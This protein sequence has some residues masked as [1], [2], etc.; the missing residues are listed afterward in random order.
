MTSTL[1]SRWQEILR[2]EAAAKV[3]NVLA[4]A[5]QQPEGRRLPRW[6]VPAIVVGAGLLGVLLYVV[7][8]ISVPPIVFF[9]AYSIYFFAS[10]YP[11]LQQV[12]YPA[13]A[14]PVAPPL[15]PPLPPPE[16]IG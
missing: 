5:R 16:P 3:G 9:P 14:V 13:P 1:P 2:R 4:Q 7:S 10:R 8:L 6:T 11:A 12:L 15:A